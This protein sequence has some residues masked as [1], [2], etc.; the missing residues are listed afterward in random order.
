[1]NGGLLPNS[2]RG[3]SLYGIGHIA[4]WYST[5]L[6]LAGIDP[7][8]YNVNSKSPIDSINL[9]P[10]ISGQVATSPRTTVVLDHNY[11]PNQGPPAFGAIRKNNYKLLIGPQT[12]SLWYGG[13]ENNYFSPNQSVPF[14]NQA[15]TYGSYD[16][17]ALFDLSVDPTEHND[18]ATFLPDVVADLLK[19]F[20]S[21]DSAYHIPNTFPKADGLG[22][23]TRLAQNGYV[24][25]PYLNSVDQI[26]YAPTTAPTTK[27]VAGPVSRIIHANEFVNAVDLYI[28]GASAL[29]GL[30]FG[31]TTGWAPAI[32]TNHHFQIFSSGITP[33]NSYDWDGK[34]YVDTWFYS[35]VARRTVIFVGDD[36]GSQVVTLQEDNK[37][38]SS[39]NFKWRF[40]H[41]TKGFQSVDVYLLPSGSNVWNSAPSAYGVPYG[42]AVPD[43]NNPAFETVAGNYFIVLTAAGSKNILFSSGVKALTAGSEYVTIGLK[44]KGYPASSPHPLEILVNEY[45][46]GS[47][48]VARDAAAHLRG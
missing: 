27:P 21:Y 47:T 43:A 19:D 14:P 1:M 12:L 24:V 35:N 23:C 8:D 48:Y 20:H 10:W 46:A 34:A 6:N 32:T 11:L 5:F 9:W 37:V 15:I 33:K 31:Q 29:K 3:K 41:G 44:D 13:S 4:D 22:Y 16:K 40:V 17:P 18:L 26:V 7:T 45:A 36:Y 30:V 42:N 38:P 39:D 25:A 2:Q 28:N